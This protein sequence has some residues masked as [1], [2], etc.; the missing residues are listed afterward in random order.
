MRLSVTDNRRLANVVTTL[1][2]HSAEPRVPFF[3]ALTLFRRHLWF[4]TEQNHGNMR[5]FCF[6]VTMQEFIGLQGA[7]LAW[8]K[9]WSLFSSRIWHKFN[10]KN[11]PWRTIHSKFFYFLSSC[12][13]FPYRWT[14][15]ASTTSKIFF[16]RSSDSTPQMVGYKTRL[17]SSEPKF[18][19]SDANKTIILPNYY[20]G[21]TG[22]LVAVK[23]NTTRAG[24]IELQVGTTLNA[25]MWK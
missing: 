6:N 22:R 1:A 15:K 3:F 8:I 25:R 2:T 21:K 9:C 12:L 19:L 16:F 11:Y 7:I 20:F 23:S 14:K 18:N 17:P 10:K 5:C 13:K 24:H 4:I